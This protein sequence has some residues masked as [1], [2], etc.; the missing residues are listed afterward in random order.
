VA[1]RELARIA[2]EYCYVESPVEGHVADDF[3]MDA[4][5]SVAQGI[6]VARIVAKDTLKA[7]ASL[8]GKLVSQVKA[9]RTRA[10]VEVEGHPGRITATVTTVNPAVDPMRRATDIEC[11]F[12]NP[13][14]EE[15]N[16]I[17]S[18]GRF[19]RVHVVLK[20]ETG[21]VVPASA[22]CKDCAAPSVIVIDE[23]DT[24]LPTH[25]KIGLAT[26]KKVVI[27]EGLE[28]TERIIREGVLATYKGAR[29]TIIEE[30]TQ[31]KE[32]EE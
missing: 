18:P 1:A 25:V 20:S 17:L 15:G 5:D 2:L 24:M 14:D 29:V 10:Y 28:G 13:K 30:G 21:L 31:A 23:K 8:P 6:P 9:G 12:Q 26:T 4:G 3:Y 32:E 7:A 19:A 16:L 11:L 27:R 22:L